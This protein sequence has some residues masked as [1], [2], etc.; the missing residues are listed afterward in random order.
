[1]GTIGPQKG[2]EP[3]T[4]Y[5]RP[6]F[7]DYLGQTSTSTIPTTT[8]TLIKKSGGG[9]RGGGSFSIPS[10]P[11]IPIPD[12]PRPSTPFQPTV[13]F[14]TNGRTNVRQNFKPIKR[15]YGLR[16]VQARQIDYMLFEVSAF[17][18]QRFVSMLIR[19]RTRAS[20]INIFK[21]RVR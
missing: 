21:S 19:A 11:S 1:M 3:L 12:I 2:R 18:N 20:A 10:V 14:Q 6:P 9:S 17:V 7:T 15:F 5:T 8:T 13:T 16:N 4:D